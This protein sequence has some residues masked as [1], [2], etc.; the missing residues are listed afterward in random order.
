M[1]GERRMFQLLRKSQSCW[2]K[3]V[4][5]VVATF[6]LFPKQSMPFPTVPKD[7]NPT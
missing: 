7:Q 2:R 6:L 3:M 5:E 1:M 4:K